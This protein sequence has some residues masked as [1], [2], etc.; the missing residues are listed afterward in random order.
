MIWGGGDEMRVDEA[1]ED[2]NT[3]DMEDNDK[4]KEDEMWSRKEEEGDRA[5]RTGTYKE[6]GS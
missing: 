4:V 5:K 1:N 6:M 2:E 3:G